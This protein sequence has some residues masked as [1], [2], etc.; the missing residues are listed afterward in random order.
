MKAKF[1]TT[2]FVVAFLGTSA[3]PCLAQDDLDMAADVIIV[4]PACVVATAVG[5]ALFVVALPFSAI[6]KSVRK[7]AH[8]FVVRPAKAAFTRPLG[9]MD[10]LRN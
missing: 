2:L 6:S 10:A 5:S 8:A 3:T 1:L 4:R 7:S 9:D